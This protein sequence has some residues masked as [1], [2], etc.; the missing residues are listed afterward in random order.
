MDIAP[1][2]LDWSLI[3]A[4]LAVAE[5]GSLSAAARALRQSQPTLGRQIRAL[6]TQLGT[7]L[8]ERHARGFTLTA[9]GE[10]LLP[11][12]VQ[13]REASMALTLA[14]A[15]QAA[16]L[17]GTVR[18]TASVFV[19]NFVL[20]DVLADIRRTEPSVQIELAPNDGSENLLFREADIALRMYRPTQLDV[21]TAH[22]VDL[23]LGCF[24]ARSYL[25]RKGRPH[26]PEDLFDHDLIG[27]DRSDLILRTMRDLGWPATRD[28]FALRCDDQ[29][30]YWQLVRAGC[31]V[32]FSQVFVGRADPLV[33][34]ID[35]GLPIPSLPLWLAAHETLY[36][37]PR[38]HR[39][40]ALLS[41]GLKDRYR[42]SD[43]DPDGVSR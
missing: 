40:W 11:H 41:Q 5:A 7:A 26:R 30:A 27:Y 32:G 6:E 8:F 21:V 13:M 33:E 42:S 25:E 3:P 34:E 14:N 10:A 1:E 29:A 39:I 35:L 37:T 9:E 19:S 12:A 16:Q 43:V 23:P 24:A 18:M 2:T 38:V 31:G 4:F 28:D 36:R 15:G 20:P 22:I 17:A